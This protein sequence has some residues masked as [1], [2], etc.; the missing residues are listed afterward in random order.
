[1]EGGRLGAV[2][3]QF[4]WSFRANE[5]NREW[6]DDVLHAFATYPLVVEVRHDSWLSAEFLNGLAERGVG[7]VNIDQP[8]LSD[9][10]EPTAIATAPVGYVRV[11]GRNY[12]DWFRK[13]AGVEKRYDYLYSA[14]VLKPWAERVEEV[15]ICAG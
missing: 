4:P 10:V 13:G 1:M 7:F 9:S 6:L 8:Q 15:V 11:H 12:H 5:E 3:V 14:K 2:L